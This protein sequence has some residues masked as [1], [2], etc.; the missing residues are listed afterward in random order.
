ML[1]NAGVDGLGLTA[2]RSRVAPPEHGRQTEPCQGDGTLAYRDLIL[3]HFL[4][5][6]SGAARGLC[7]VVLPKALPESDAM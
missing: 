3:R 2:T 1:Y 5:A 7:H 4:S 6:E